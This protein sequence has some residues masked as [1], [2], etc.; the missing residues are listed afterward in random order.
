[1]FSIFKKFKRKKIIPHIR[2]SGV[3]GA[4][5]RFK[6]GLDFV[7]QKEIIEKAFSIKIG[8]KKTAAK[9]FMRKSTQLLALLNTL[10]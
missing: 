4:V 3:I 2:L 9:Y 6:Q 5:G 10:N 8:K 1:M 7:G